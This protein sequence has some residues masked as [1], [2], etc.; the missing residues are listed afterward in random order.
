MLNLTVKDLAQHDHDLRFCNYGP[1]GIA[2]TPWPMGSH[3]RKLCMKRF[4]LT[5]GGVEAL[6]YFTGEKK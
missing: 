4:I 1:V 5:F 3:T 2:K 6:K